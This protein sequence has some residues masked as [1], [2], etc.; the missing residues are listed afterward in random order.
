MASEIELGKLVKV[1]ITTFETPLA[2]DKLRRCWFAIRPEDK[3]LNFIIDL[4]LG[5][6]W[7]I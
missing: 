1:A 3:Y 7:Q 6:D 2:H 5:E 4:D